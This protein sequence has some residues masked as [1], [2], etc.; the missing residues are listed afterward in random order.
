[1]NTY[2]VPGTVLNTLHGLLHVVSQPNEVLSLLQVRRPRFRNLKSPKMTP[3]ID[4][5]GIQIQVSLT[6]KLKFLN[7]YLKWYFLCS[8]FLHHLHLFL[9]CVYFFFP[10][11]HLNFKLF[12]AKVCNHFVLSPAD[13]LIKYWI[14]TC[15]LICVC[16]MDEL[17]WS[18]FFPIDL[19]MVSR[20]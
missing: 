13:C 16:W 20:H 7:R 9:P 12:K 5:A 19:A 11:S 18:P 10:F 1:M 4:K 15:L 3:V 2:Y 6:Q 17:C 8:E 14:H